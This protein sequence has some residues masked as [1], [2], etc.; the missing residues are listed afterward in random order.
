MNEPLILNQTL[1]EKIQSAIDCAFLHCEQLKDEIF[2]AK[3]EIK[4]K[5]E[6]YKK[7]LKYLEILCEASGLYASEK[8]SGLTS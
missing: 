1:T 8:V 2:Q 5:E 7:T 4:K 3:H 6:E